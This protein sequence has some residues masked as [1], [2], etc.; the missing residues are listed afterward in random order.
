MDI[1]SLQVPRAGRSR[2]SKALP[3]PP[4]GLDDRPQTALRD[5]PNVP[6][7]PLPPKKN[8]ILIT[9]PSLPNLRSKDL[10]SPLPILPIMAEPARPRLAGPISRKPV[11]QLS[12]PQA[13]VG[14][15]KSKAMKRK[16]SISSLLSAYSR[17]SSDWGASHESD[18]TKDSEPSYSPER[19]GINSLPPVPSKNSM[20]TTNDTNSDRT[21]EVTSYTI[22]DSFPPP[23]PS[24][25]P[26]RPRTPSPGTVGP[27]DGARDR[28]RG[29]EGGSVSLSPVSVRSGSSRAGPHEIWRRRA[30]SKSDASLVIAELKLPGSN[31][32]TAS[33]AHIPAEKAELPSLPPPLPSKTSHQPALPLPPKPN[34]QS[35][36]TLPPRTVSLPGRNIRPIKKTEPLNEEDEMKKLMKLSKLKELVRGRGGDDDSEE[37]QKKGEQHERQEAQKP[38]DAKSDADKP[39]PPVKDYG[40]QKPQQRQADAPTTAAGEANL[41]P[42]SP[43]DTAGPQQE[44][45]MA[46]AAAI[47]RRPVGAQPAASNPG[48]SQAPRLELEFEKKNTN[49]P[50]LQQPSI[51]PA[52]T[53]L[54]RTPAGA[55]PHPSQRQQQQQHQQHQQQQQPPP[56]PQQQQQHQQ[57]QQ[58]QHH[59][60]QQQRPYRGPPANPY[61]RSGP[62]S[63]TGAGPRSVSTSAYPSQPAAMAMTGVHRPPGSISTGSSPRYQSHTSQ[64]VSPGTG[65]S[66]GRGSFSTPQFMGPPRAPNPPF[67]SQPSTFGSERGPAAQASGRGANV[68]EYRDVTQQ[69]DQPMS[70]EAAAALAVFHRKH[71]WESNCTA[72]GVWP[73]YPL[74]DRHYNC[75][76]NHI[77]IV[78]SRN[79]YYSLACQTCGTAD[80]E[81]RYVCTYCNLRVC[82]SCVELLTANG[83][84]LRATMDI[85][86]EQGRIKDWDQ[87]PKRSTNQDTQDTQAP[88]PSS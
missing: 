34:Q 40:M 53:S 37:E 78:N 39:E 77:K 63:P 17:S 32:S 29:R 62:T 86:R 11:A 60:Q 65:R 81:R 87:Y 38:P 7:A 76:L 55:L 35:A 31:G 79:T 22:I 4:P 85:L 42:V 12:I 10:D 51:Q 80:K 74:A 9:R 71:D 66:S 5:L 16:S 57:Q 67:L 83:R 44:S 36:V 70:D 6:P 2:F 30:S 50:N 73:P 47:A 69:P 3:T 72:D 1:S 27:V 56:P 88:P 84:N 75:H 59:H 58:Q 13:T 49:L 25:D 18:F 14:D 15:T 46:T 20:E 28:I 33:T 8:S 64:Q 61:S 45:G 68:T 21:S 54:P 23:P 19:E 48:P 43:S 82:V 41:S 52:R 26:S 24:K